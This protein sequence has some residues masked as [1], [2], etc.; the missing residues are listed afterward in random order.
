MGSYQDTRPLSTAAYESAFSPARTSPTIDRAIHAA[1]P[2]EGFI[3]RNIAGSLERFP[4]ARDS[5][6]SYVKSCVLQQDLRL[7]TLKHQGC[8][9]WQHV[10]KPD[11][12]FKSR[13]LRLA[14]IPCCLRLSLV[15]DLLRRKRRR[16]EA[17]TGID[18]ASPMARV[19]GKHGIIRRMS[20]NTQIEAEDYDVH[21][22]CV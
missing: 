7:L 11:D 13:V 18:E 5:R 10:L 9:R 6:Q 3:T 20:Q 12:S 2:D 21:D 16:D 17:A 15:M 22:S 19:Y 4:H 1:T 14:T 8:P